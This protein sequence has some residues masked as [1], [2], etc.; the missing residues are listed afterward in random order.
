[1]IKRYEEFLI[2]EKFDDNIKGELSRLGVTDKDEI[3]R[4]LYHAHRGN[5]GKYLKE[6]G[7]SMTFGLLKSLFLD[8]QLAKKR[9]DLKIGA[10]KAVHRIV[11]MALAPFFPILAIVG[12]ILGT[13]RAFNKVIAP[14]LADPGSDYPEFLNKLIISTM[15]I[16]E[17]E[18]IPTKDRFSRAFVV[19]DG[20]VNML[21]EPVLRDF[22]AYLS[23]VMENQD[24][25]GEVPDHYIENELKSY[26]NK[27]YDIYPPIPLRD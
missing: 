23:S 27:R 17:G 2:T 18:I 12:Y 4:H 21:S 11:P 13:S 14:I 10:I 3:N 16:A 6:K 25:D 8:A 9:T 26:L 1:M 22:A 15:K 5:L 24:Q 7:M 20:I 19:S